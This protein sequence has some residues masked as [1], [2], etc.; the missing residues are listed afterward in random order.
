MIKSR[1][2]KWAGHIAR[3]WKR[4]GAYKCLA[5]KREGKRALKRTRSKWEDNIK[6]NLPEVG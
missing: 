5:G 2:I 6:K 1:R 4:R 3:M